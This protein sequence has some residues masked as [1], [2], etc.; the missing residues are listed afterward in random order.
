[1]K[2]LRILLADDHD[3]VRLGL[4]AMIEREPNWKVCAE[5]ST[6]KEAIAA[7]KLL[8]PEIAVLDMGLPDMDGLEATRQLRRLLPTCEILIFTGRESDELIQKVYDLGAKGFI[9]KS[10]ASK[11][12]IEAIKSLA[13]HR[14]F[15][16]DKAS[17]VVFAKFNTRKP[18]PA[19]SGDA[20]RLTD[21]ERDLLILLA[22]GSSNS[23]AARKMKVS[24]RTIEN[25][26]AEMM[27]KLKID[28][29]ANL[30][31]Y[32]VRNKFISA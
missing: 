9:L 10:E 14:P 19:S 32:A 28:S 5:V 18:E 21:R 8:K 3:M 25:L 11:Y 27:R 26:R 4:K 13:D 20:G 16:T 22:S 23:V 24:T 30:V 29:F 17:A 1:M 2:K 7:A 31:R 6:G 15:F 12:L